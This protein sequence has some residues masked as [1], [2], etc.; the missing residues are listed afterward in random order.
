[1]N[2]LIDSRDL[3]IENY[4]KGTKSISKNQ[5]QFMPSKKKTSVCIRTQALPLYSSLYLFPEEAIRIGAE[6]TQVRLR[7]LPQN[8]RED[9]TIDLNDVNNTLNGLSLAAKQTLKKI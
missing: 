8:V 2:R 9:R 1:M 3:S 6:L 5:I 4:Q 7:I